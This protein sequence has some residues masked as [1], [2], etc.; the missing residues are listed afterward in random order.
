MV[1]FLRQL[2]IVVFEILA[3]KKYQV[4]ITDGKAGEKN[5][6]NGSKIPSFLFLNLHVPILQWKEKLQVILF[7]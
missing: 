5:R 2:P 4:G 3:K 1:N 6:V 7:P